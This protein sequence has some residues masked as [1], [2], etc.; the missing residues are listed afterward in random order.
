MTD[1]KKQPRGKTAFLSGYLI[2]NHKFILRNLLILLVITC[3]WT[4]SLCTGLLSREGPSFPGGSGKDSG[5]SLSA[6]EQA[7][8]L[9]SQAKEVSFAGLLCPVPVN[10]L[11]KNS[12]ADEVCYYGNGFALSISL[13]G[14]QLGLPAAASVTDT[15][16]K[17]QVLRCVE[18]RFG[19]YRGLEQES[20]VWQDKAAVRIHIREA[21]VPPSESP[22]YADLLLV[23]TERGILCLELDSRGSEELNRLLFEEIST[24]AGLK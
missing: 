6:Q 23:D 5:I 16:S 17:K 21:L 11:E 19:S 13:P 12:T 10:W 20:C 3:L 7:D 24:R 1:L 15:E 4:V 9:L 8:A 2:R 18:E 22:V 14:Q